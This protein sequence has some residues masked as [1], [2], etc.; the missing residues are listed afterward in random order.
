MK[1]FFQYA[2]LEHGMEFLM[3]IGMFLFM[4]YLFIQAV[5]RND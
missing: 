2:I 4:L 3:F 1:E 5:R